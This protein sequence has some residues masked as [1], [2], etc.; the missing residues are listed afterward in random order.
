MSYMRYTLS[1]AYDIVWHS[2]LPSH[3]ILQVLAVEGVL[4]YRGEHFWR[5]SSSVVCGTLHV[6]VQPHVSEAKVIQQ[7][8]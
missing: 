2:Y 8:S 7:V 5:H 3:V 6:Q 1:S 4:S